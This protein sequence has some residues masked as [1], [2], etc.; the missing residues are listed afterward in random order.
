MRLCCRTQHKMYKYNIH[1]VIQYGYKFKS[2]LKC[3]VLSMKKKRSIQISFTSFY[4]L[5][6]YFWSRYTPRLSW[7]HAI[8]L[9]SIIYIEV[10]SL[11]L[12]SSIN[13]ILLT[14]FNAFLNIHK[15]WAYK[16]LKFWFDLIFNNRE[17]ICIL[18]LM[19][20]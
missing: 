18:I 13:S 19:C 4:I 6:D 2:M 12:F 20:H 10:Q 11:T 3:A 5:L 16:N 17:N 1:C 9:H 15:I 7:P 8:D 14:I